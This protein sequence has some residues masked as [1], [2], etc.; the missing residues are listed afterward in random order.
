MVFVSSFQS[1][2]TN[3]YFFQELIFEVVPVCKKS[4]FVPLDHNVEN[5][6]PIS[7]K[8]GFY[9]ERTSGDFLQNLIFEVVP[10]CKKSTFVPIG[11]HCSKWYP[12]FCEK[13][14]PCL[15]ELAEIFYKN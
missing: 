3:G 1:R 9:V 4:T 8:N 11:S 7:T 10:L 14:T 6:T 5:S 13:W 15:R 2:D 12:D